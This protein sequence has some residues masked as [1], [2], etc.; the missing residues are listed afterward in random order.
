MY[1]VNFYLPRVIFARDYHEFAADADF[2]TRLQPKAKYGLNPL[3]IKTVEIGMA[4]TMYVGVMYAG[5]KPGK[6]EIN[7]F[8]KM[9]GVELE[10]D[11]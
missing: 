5:H 2:M 10:L 6:N 3:K 4:G 11:D 1:Q 7:R 9:E 8:L